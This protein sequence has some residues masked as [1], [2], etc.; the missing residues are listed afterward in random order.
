LS[1]TQQ[2]VQFAGVQL[3]AP[4][5]PVTAS[6]TRPLVVQVTHASPVFPHA[7]GSVPLRQRV[8]PWSRVQQPSQ[9][10]ARQPGWSRPQT[11]ASLQES[12]PSAVQS[13]QRSPIDPQARLSCPF[14]QTPA[15]SQQ[16]SGHVAG[17]QLAAAP[18][19]ASRGISS[20]R[21]ERPQPGARRTTTT[22]KTVARARK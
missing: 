11:R 16:P 21:L 19:P 10:E 4:Q 6:Q 3:V 15:E 18:A 14:R 5:A 17:P 1:P 22:P 8:R 7:A 2:P 13:E 20:S 12:K 9:F